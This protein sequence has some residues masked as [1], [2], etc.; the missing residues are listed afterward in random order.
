MHRIL[1]VKRVYTPLTIVDSASIVI[2]NGIV[3]KIVR[4]WI[5]NGENLKDFIA[6]PGFVDT[7]IHGCYGYDA[8][9]A[10]L[11]DLVGMSKNLV[12]HGVTSFLPT[13]VTL[14]LQKI[15]EAIDAVR[16][17][18]EM[19]LRNDFVGARILGI[20]LEGPFINVEMKGAQNP[21][22]IRIPKLDEFKSIVDRARDVV[23]V[24]TVAPELGEGLEIVSY[25]RS[26]G[27][28][29]SLGHSAA[30]YDEALK[31]IERGLDRATH[32]FNAMKRFHHREP[33][34]VLALLQSPS[35][36]LEIIAD[37]IH[38]HPAVVKMIIEYAGWRR[39]VLITDA[40]SAT[41]LPDG[42]YELGGLKVIVR[43]GIAR[44]V[45]GTLAGSTL[46]MDRAIRNVVSLGI[47]LWKAIAMASYV[48]ARSID[49][50]RLGCLEPGCVA[51]I[52]LLDE[53]LNVVK[54][55]VG[56]VDAYEKP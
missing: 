18:R 39:T 22:Y 24:V 4:G 8:S 6:V 37:F 54:T 55:I 38:L 5:E 45:D 49:E 47:E 27:I 20:N 30:G 26:M 44:L 53:D 43:N 17:A 13:T 16:K 14:P 31:A 25:A 46:T 48:P 32:L 52:V 41:G 56:G 42:E 33:G 40:I 15:F 11:D 21:E 36:Y 12:R 51:D 7:H 50:Y 19:Q 29:V 34:A 9:N 23:K 3:K 10:K 35:V 28:H 2:E 1:N